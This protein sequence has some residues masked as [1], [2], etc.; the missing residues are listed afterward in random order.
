MKPPIAV[1]AAITG[2]LTAA[3]TMLAIERTFAQMRGASH[4]ATETELRPVSSFAKIANRRARS[5]ALFEEGAKV[6]QHPRCMN[7]H[8]ATEGH[9]PVAVL[10]IASSAAAMAVTVPSTSWPSACRFASQLGSLYESHVL[11]DPSCQTN[12]F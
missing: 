6:L 11:P 3:A 2:A 8:P 9:D 7:C 12:A 4:P 5:I 10:A 1:V